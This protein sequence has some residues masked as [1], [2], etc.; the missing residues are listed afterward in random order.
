MSVF[1]MWWIM[2]HFSVSIENYNFTFLD[3]T[4]LSPANNWKVDA[5]LHNFYELH[6][7]LSGSAVLYINGE[8]VEI[9]KN[10]LLF[11]NRNNLHYTLS[12]SED[13]K[14][15]SFSFDININ[16][17]QPLSLLDYTSVKNALFN[18]NDYLV[19]KE[20]IFIDIFQEFYEDTTISVLESKLHHTALLL[21]FGLIG[22]LKKRPNAL[23]VE[24]FKET[25]SKYK[26]EIIKIDKYISEHYME[27]IGIKDLAK[28]FY[29][30]ERQMSRIFQSLMGDSFHK[31]LLRQ[32]MNVAVMHLKNGEIPLTEI[33]F[34]C[35]FNSYSGFFIAFKK[36]FNLS[37]NEYKDKLKSPQD[38][39]N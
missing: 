38:K 14:F 7:I 37:P 22:V 20:Q 26:D 6:Y 35:G 8:T 9:N 39:K 15:V 19:V 18:T 29:L 4:L 12:H 5:H 16:H 10:E 13:L 36:Y 17:N 31:Y 25:S 34:V 27:D 23:K 3:G 24:L 28:K 33:P 11:I 21:F 2:N 32:R 30:S 1:L